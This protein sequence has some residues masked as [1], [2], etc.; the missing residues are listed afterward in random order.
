MA[1]F[2]LLRTNDRT[3]CVSFLP[4]TWSHGPLWCT[5]RSISPDMHVLIV[6]YYAPTP[7]ADDAGPLLSGRVSHV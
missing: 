7:E 1:F 5:L 4:S 3:C 6:T 2:F